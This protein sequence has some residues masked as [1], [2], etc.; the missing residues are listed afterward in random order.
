MLEFVDASLEALLRAT[1]PLSATDVDVAFEAPSREWSAKLN[2]PTVNLFLWDIRR[3]TDRA[4]TGMEQV[5]RNGQRIRRLALPRVELRYL[6]TAWTSEHRDERALLGGLLR[7][8]LAHHE[9]PRTY[10]AAGIADLDPPAM[11][12]ARA[13]EAQVD[14]LKTLEGQIKPALDLVITTE[15]DI[16]GGEPLAAPVGEVSVG[17]FDTNQPTRR[18]ELRR[19]AG[20]V[21]VEGA[22]GARV[23]SP[24]GGAVVNSA[25]RFLINAAPGDEITVELDP[26]RTALVPD[27]GG[28]VIS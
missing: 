15:V 25:S 4:R 19:V 14:I 22:I 7:V 1:V 13:G 17:L 21:L 18:A 23:R 12:V 28:V 2:R 27:H 3:A 8:A 16:G 10:V 5:E 6:M 26:P 9:I 24:R 20:E 11:M